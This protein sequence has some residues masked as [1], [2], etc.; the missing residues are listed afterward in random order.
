MVFVI[1]TVAEEDADPRRLRLWEA[2]DV[3]DSA[4]GSGER[5]VC[6]LD[7]FDADFERAARGLRGFTDVCVGTSASEGTSKTSSSVFATIG[8]TDAICL[9]EGFGTDFAFDC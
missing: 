7:L 4:E 9:P 6:D 3:S 2:L 5:G 8:D 1:F